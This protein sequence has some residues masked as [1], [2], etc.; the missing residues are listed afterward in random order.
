MRPGGYAVENPVEAR[1]MRL[2]ERVRTRSVS[3]ARVSHDAERRRARA[4]VIAALPGVLSLL[5]NA[6]T[7]ANDHLSDAG[8]WLTLTVAERSPTAEAL[9]M[10][11]VEDPLSGKEPSLAITVDFSGRMAFLLQREDVRSLVRASTVFTVDNPIV[12]E[13][14]VAFLEARYP[15][16]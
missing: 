11:T 4:K 6:V 13:A 16:K 2:V 7:E 15:E 5:S 14:I 12:A 9:F 3:E 1:L 8:L 10:I